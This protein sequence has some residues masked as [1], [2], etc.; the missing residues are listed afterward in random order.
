M[1]AC[2]WYSY[3]FTAA[4]SRGKQVTGVSEMLSLFSSWQ[5]VSAALDKRLVQKYDRWFLA[6]TRELCGKLC[7]QMWKWPGHVHLLWLSRVHCYAKYACYD[8]TNMDVSAPHICIF[9][10]IP[11]IPLIQITPYM[12]STRPCTPFT[13]CM[14]RKH[15]LHGYLILVTCKC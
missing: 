2:L 5:K 15:S 11:G 13:P 7:E 1:L 9:I 10:D 8:I 12:Y 14:C 3:L 4:R 6:T